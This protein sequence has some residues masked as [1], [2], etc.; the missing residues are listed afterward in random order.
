MRWDCDS[1]FRAAFAQNILGKAVSSHASQDPRIYRL[2]TRRLSGQYTRPTCARCRRLLAP[3]PHLVDHLHISLEPSSLGWDP[4]EKK[5]TLF[6][7][8]SRFILVYHR[9][10]PEHPAATLVAFSMFRFELGYEDDDTIYWYGE[11]IAPPH[12]PSNISRCSYEMQVSEGFRGYGICRFFVEKLKLVGKHWQL[13][14]LL[15]T[16]LKGMIYSLIRY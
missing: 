3:L 10:T 15:L 14:K 13:E 9:Q 7:Q 2:M 16:A 11:F 8:D 12:M 1:F 4:D 6:D 5:E